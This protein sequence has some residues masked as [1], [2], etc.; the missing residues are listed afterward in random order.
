MYRIAQNLHIDEARRRKT[1][2]TEVDIEDR[3]DIAGGDGL[4]LVEGRSDLAMARAAVAS[5][6]EDQRAV[7]ALVVLEGLSYRD[8]A[9][10]LGVPLGTVMSRLSRARRAIDNAVN[11][12]VAND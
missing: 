11:R 3:Q 12:E 7:V 5:L 8:A 10:T 9:E 1:R 4:R 2:G 6:P